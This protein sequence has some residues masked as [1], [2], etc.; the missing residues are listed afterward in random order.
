[1]ERQTKHR[2]LG[3]LVLI[4]LVIILLPFF[5]HSSDVPSD[6]AT[7]KAPPFPDQSIQVSSNSVDDNAESQ[8]TP[9]TPVI[10]A[11]PIAPNNNSQSNSSTM[12]NQNSNMDKGLSDQPDDTINL[13]QQ[14]NVINMKTPEIIPPALQPITP[15]P[16]TNNQTPSTSAA[17]KNTNVSKKENIEKKET[18]DEQ[19]SRLITE[20]TQS[21]DSTS[22]DEPA[23][24]EV[25]QKKPAKKTVAIKSKKQKPL[26]T[27]HLRAGEIKPYLSLIDKRKENNSSSDKNGLVKLKNAS[28]VIQVG[29]FKNKPAA[30][31]LVNKLR[32]KGYRSFIQ[33]INDESSDNI[34][35][36]VGPENKQTAARTLANDLENQFKLQSIVLSY[37]PLAL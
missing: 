28:W 15:A 4:G 3:V 26:V 12:P 35:V 17:D 2:I 11:P 8:A 6:P 19:V 7:L 31:R 27:S 29:T 33:Q 16:E 10:P 36:F 25:P 32:Q 14:P 1:M 22:S 9:N 5:Q 30:L 24:T 21:A 20:S 13:N 18:T 23:N 34:R 37:K